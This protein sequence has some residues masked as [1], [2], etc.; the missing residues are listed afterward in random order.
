[1]EKEGLVRALAFLK[2]ESLSVDVLVTDRHRQIA[3]Y[4]REIHPEI[5]HYYDVWHLAKG[6]CSHPPLNAI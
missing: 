4:V 2:Q 1:M 3:K 5:K 6:K